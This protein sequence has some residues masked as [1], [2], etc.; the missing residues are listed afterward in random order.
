MEVEY[1]NIQDARARLRESI[2]IHKT[3]ADLTQFSLCD[4]SALRQKNFIVRPCFLSRARREYRV[5]L[6]HALR[7]AAEGSKRGYDGKLDRI[8]LWRMASS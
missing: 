4:F 2:G 5:E 3:Q 7:L 6:D 8:F 1:S